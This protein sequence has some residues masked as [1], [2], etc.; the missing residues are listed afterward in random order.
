V[1]ALVLGVAAM[2][3]IRS[4]GLWAMVLFALAGLCL[5]FS[6]GSYQAAVE[7]S[8]LQTPEVPWRPWEKWF[9]LGLLIYAAFTRSYLLGTVPAGANGH[10]GQIAGAVYDLEQAGLRNYVAHWGGDIQYPTLTFYQSLFCV[11]LFGHDPAVFRMP[12]VLWAVLLLGLFYLLARRISSPEVAVIGTLLLSADQYT[13]VMSRIM[14]PGII[15]MIAPVGGFYFLLKGMETGRL[16]AFAVGGVLGGLSLHSYIPGRVFGPLMVCWLVWLL[17]IRPRKVIG[18]WKGLLVYAGSFLGMGSPVIYFALKYPGTYWGAVEHSNPHLAMGLS[19]SLEWILGTARAYLGMFHVQGD[20]NLAMQ[21]PHE[22][23]FNPVTNFL[24]PLGLVSCLIFFWRPVPAYLLGSLVAGMIPA[25][26]S[27]GQDPPA[28]RRVVAIIPIVYLFIVMAL[29]RL[30]RGFNP[31]NRIWVNRFLTAVGILAAIW[32]LALGYHNYFERWAKDPRVLTQLSHHYYRASQVMKKYPEVQTQVAVYLL[33]EGRPVSN[34][35]YPRDRTVTFFQELEDLWRVDPETE[36]LFFIDPLFEPDLPFIRESFPGVEARAF[37]GDNMSEPRVGRLVMVYLSPEVLR[38]ARG[39][40]VEAPGQERRVVSLRDF[41]RVME[42]LKGKQVELRFMLMLPRKPSK[43]G[44]KTQ[45][46]GWTLRVDGR[47]W[48]EKGR[49]LFLGGPHFLH[50]SGRVPPSLSPGLPVTIRLLEGD[51]HEPGIFPVRGPFGLRV[52]FYEDPDD[53][54]QEATLSRVLSVPRYPFREY[55][56]EP[57]HIPF[58]VK[59]S[60]WIQAEEA[61]RYSISIP[62]F[63]DARVEIDGKPVFVSKPGGAGSSSFFVLEAGQ[64]RLMTVYHQVGHVPLEERVL[65]LRWMRQDTGLEEPMAA[66]LMRPDLEGT[67]T[68]LAK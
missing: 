22:P 46:P 53:R 3:I 24:L 15:T 30:R 19:Q 34:M 16:W 52:W 21:I 17:V 38:G 41:S 56:F 61:G 9:L 55:P 35:F 68:A 47:P 8:D 67:W 65:E 42:G 29:E 1:G 49:A 45:W 32:A 4:Q 7:G 18:S 54:N 57:L 14:F 58:A 44:I 40:F 25:I 39:V 5:I 63:K 59:A 26:L 27:H 13:F 62:R 51:G 6:T 12:S 37:G 20:W 66:S 33:R 50:L 64:P 31:W 28:T 36:H 2:M 11:K 23:M 60:A 10:E 43:V 48:T